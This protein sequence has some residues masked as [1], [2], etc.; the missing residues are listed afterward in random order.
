MVTGDP[1][2]YEAS[3]LRSCRERRS[4]EAPA[5]GRMMPA[6]ALG[7]VP[8][9]GHAFGQPKAAAVL[10]SRCALLERFVRAATT[11]GPTESVPFRAFTTEDAVG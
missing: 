3:S 9:A 2:R 4:D 1:P 10:H 11:R 7:H 6:A 8:A 5:R